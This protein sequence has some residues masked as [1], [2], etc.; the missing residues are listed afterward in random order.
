VT[1]TEWAARWGLPDA[2]LAELATVNMDVPVA[3]AAGKSEAYVQSRVRQEAE[4]KG[5]YLWRNNRGAFQDKTGR[6]VRYGLANDSK[7]VDAILKSSDLIGIEKVLIGPEHVGHIIGRLVSCECKP[8]G[9]TYK[10]TEREQ[11]Q[12]RWLQLINAMGGRALFVNRE[13]L[14]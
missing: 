3:S 9:W 12:L 6:L 13:G 1:L 5:I 4:R 8:E 14:L 11:A 7:T 10:G 2:A